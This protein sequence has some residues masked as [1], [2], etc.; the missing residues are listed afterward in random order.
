MTALLLRLAPGAAAWR[1]VVVC[2]PDPDRL[3]AAEDEVRDWLEGGAAP[4]LVLL[5]STRLGAPH[6]LVIGPHDEPIWVPVTALVQC[7]GGAQAMLVAPV[8]AFGSRVELHWLPWRVPADGD[9]WWI[10]I[11]I[12]EDH[13]LFRRWDPEASAA[14]GPLLRALA[15]DVIDRRGAPPSTEASDSAGGDVRRIQLAGVEPSSAA[16]IARFLR[17]GS[18]TE[19]PQALPSRSVVDELSPGPDI[20]AIVEGTTPEPGT[21]TPLLEACGPAGPSARGD[22]SPLPVAVPPVVDRNTGPVSTHLGQS[23]AQLP[24]AAQN[25]TAPQGAV[26]ARD[27]V[28][29]SEIAT[30]APLRPSAAEPSRAAPLS[31]TVQAPRAAQPP[32]VAQRPSAAEPSSAAPLSS[33]VQAPRAAQPPDVAQQPTA[34]ASSAARVSAMVPTSHAAQPPDIA[35]RPDVAQ[36][37]SAA[38]PSSA[39]QVFAVPTSH[40]ARPPD[41]AR[42]AGTAE[43]SRTAQ[44]PDVAQPL[45]VAQRSSAAEVSRAARPSRT[46]RASHA[47]Q[48]PDIAQGSGSAE[49]A[50]AAQLPDVTQPSRAP[51]PSNVATLAAQPSNVARPSSAAEASRAARSSRDAHAPSAAHRSDTGETSSATPKPGIVPPSHAARPSDAIQSSPATRLPEAVQRSD[52]TQRPDAAPATPAPSVPAARAIP[53]SVAWQRAQ[54]APRVAERSALQVAPPRL[55]ELSGSAAE[56]RETPSASERSAAAPRS[57]TPPGGT[58]PPPTVA[59]EASAMQNAVRGHAAAVAA[60]ATSTPGPA[61]VASAVPAVSSP[62][63]ASAAS[64]AST[65]APS[66]P[67]ATTPNAPARATAARAVPGAG[68]PRLVE[69]AGELAARP[70]PDLVERGD[71]ALQR[72]DVQPVAVERVTT[73]VERPIDERVPA[74]VVPS[75]RG[76]AEAEPAAARLAEVVHPPNVALGADARLLA[77]V[78][79]HE[80]AATSEPGPERSPVGSAR[81]GVVIAAGL[82]PEPE[83][84]APAAKA[85][86]SPAGPLPVP[87]SHSGSWMAPLPAV[88]SSRAESASAIDARASLPRSTALAVNVPTEPLPQGPAPRGPSVPGGLLAPMAPPASRTPE[89]RSGAPLEMSTTAAPTVLSGFARPA[90]S[91]AAIFAPHLAVLEAAPRIASAVVPRSAAWLEHGSS[92]GSPPLSSHAVHRIPPPRRSPVLTRPTARP[93]IVRAI[94]IGEI[95]VELGAPERRGQPEPPRQPAAGSLIAAIPSHRSARSRL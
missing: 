70:R 15:L 52:A 22:P 24:A 36:R 4:V 33:T 46:V 60:P 78:H 84:T 35:K 92:A 18:A 89:P 64:P 53:G 30:A 75:G 8:D 6:A 32:D 19:I 49:P 40:A 2:E 76:F 12:D 25:M 50:R 47:A 10:Q 66:S 23:G 48:P 31:S 27:R 21:A 68:A 86:D 17:Q 58:A 14:D 37:S 61:P 85:T 7:D 59:N 16:L 71:P 81:A 90:R 77:I 5:E 38:E 44:P 79:P 57:T 34:E 55:P 45:D 91:L 63:V 67:G 62:A 88:L 65:A 26:M 83:D 69:R 41:I 93:S 11:G 54:P 95:V 80:H 20:D 82:Q 74:S 51:Q 9:A 43:P 87:R 3:A 28:A 73:G 39:A 1:R 13:V 56:V 94:E 72:P 42:R 29:G